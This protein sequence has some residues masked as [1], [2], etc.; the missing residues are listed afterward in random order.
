[1]R[2]VIVMLLLATP[3]AADTSA[4]PPDLS[5]QQAKHAAR[6]V[7][8]AERWR[9]R[10]AAVFA[11]ALPARTEVEWSDASCEA[12]GRRFQRALA[13]EAF[14]AWV[15]RVDARP[16]ATERLEQCDDDC[17][18]FDRNQYPNGE[19]AAQWLHAIC[20]APRDHVRLVFWNPC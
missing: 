15:K 9:R 14:A 12:E 10:G 8:L 16:P 2:A 3:V 18:Y 11:S 13:R 5:P 4:S 19:S 17:C 1:M 6:A 20:F 7:Q